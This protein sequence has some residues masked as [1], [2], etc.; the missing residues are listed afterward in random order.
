MQNGE[1]ITGIEGDIT[2]LQE[3]DSGLPA[4][5]DEADFTYLN[6]ITDD[7]IAQTVSDN[8]GAISGLDGRV[9]TLET[10]VVQNGMDI[11]DIV[12]DIT[13]LHEFDDGLPEGLDEADFDYLNALKD[14]DIAQTVSDNTEAISGLDGRVIML[15]ENDTSSL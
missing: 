8:T 9:M 12:G 2:S 5:L 10:D 1:A 15:E 13:D 11:M 4:G 6:Q 3:F 14:N 7:D